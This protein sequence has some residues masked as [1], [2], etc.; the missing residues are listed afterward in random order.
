[1]PTVHT[2]HRGCIPHLQPSTHITLQSMGDM[3][4]Q[5]VLPRHTLFTL[6][7][8]QQS[9]VLP[10]SCYAAKYQ[11][12]RVAE[13]FVQR[14]THFYCFFSQTKP[15]VCTVCDMV[16]R[17][18]EYRVQLLSSHSDSQLEVMDRKLN[19]IQSLFLHNKLIFYL[20]PTLNI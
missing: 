3:A 12:I 5:R 6:I 7:P 2:L 10:T 14:Q 16:C 13:T 17:L 20:F 4:E 11:S 18:L 1:M 9:I 15:V 19:E 8:S